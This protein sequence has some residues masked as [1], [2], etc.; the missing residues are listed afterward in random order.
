[1]FDFL[2]GLMGSANGALGGVNLQGMGQLP[3]ALAQFNQGGPQNQLPQMQGVDPMG[4]AM[5][6][7]GMANPMNPQGAVT[8]PFP[9]MQGAQGPGMSVPEH[10]SMGWNGPMPDP[11]MS[12][13]PL[14]GI[15]P[16]LMYAGLGAM[17]GG[18]EPEPQP[19]MAPA[20]GIHK[21][22]PGNFQFGPGAQFLRRGGGR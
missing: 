14:A 3:S 12:A 2:T 11:G 20:G 1:M 10:L 16:A 18:G 19:R 15:D 4:L 22:T 8:T 9:M 5:Q 21:M 7:P 6:N 13:N 17:G